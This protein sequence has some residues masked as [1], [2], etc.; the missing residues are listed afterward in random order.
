MNIQH[1][2]RSGRWFTPV[3]LV[4]KVHR[5]LDRVDLDPATE[6]SA[7]AR[8]QAA[9]TMGWNA[10]LPETRWLFSPGTVYCNPPG[11]KKAGKSMT[12]LFWRRMMQERDS[13]LLTHGI[14]LCF[15]LEALQHTQGMGCNPVAEF[16]L[17]VPKKRIKFDLPSGFTPASPSHSNCVV[18]VPG[19]LNKAKLFQD[20]FRDTGAILNV[21]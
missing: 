2:S 7:N 9:M 18:Y 21:P 19:T 17:C 15:S 3:W 16:P 1:S 12:G 6:A 8:I 4:E 5:V 14:F 13:G 20:V 11:G 10:E